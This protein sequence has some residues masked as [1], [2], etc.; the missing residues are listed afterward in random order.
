MLREAL[1]LQTF[2]FMRAWPA[3]PLPEPQSVLS[4]YSKQVIETKCKTQLGTV[5]Y[6][7]EIQMLYA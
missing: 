7:G 2:I 3:C 4:R 1:R 5:G 6:T